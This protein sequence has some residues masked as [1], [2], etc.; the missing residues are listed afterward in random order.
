M[1]AFDNNGTLKNFVKPSAFWSA[2][3][4][5]DK[6]SEPS[7]MRLFNPADLLHRARERHEFCPWLM[8]M[9]ASLSPYK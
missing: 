8:L 4:T 5:Y 2:V 3:P 9:D 1:R 6:V 7:L